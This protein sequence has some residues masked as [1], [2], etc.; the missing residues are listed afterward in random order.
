MNDSEGIRP[1]IE[2]KGDYIELN[3]PLLPEQ[4]ASSNTPPLDQNPSGDIE[5][6]TLGLALSEARKLAHQ[7]LELID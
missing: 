3:V 7:I 4:D 1:Y 6:L 2:R 5:V